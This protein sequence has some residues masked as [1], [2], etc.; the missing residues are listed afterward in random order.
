MGLTWAYMLCELML[1]PMRMNFRDIVRLKGR[2]HIG[3]T[4][5]H[6][7]AIGES[8]LGIGG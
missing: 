6:Q 4:Y 1:D 8:G 2:P 3:V 7:P 5:I